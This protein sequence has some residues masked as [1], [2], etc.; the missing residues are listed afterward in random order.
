MPEFHFKTGDYIKGNY[1]PYGITNENMILGR[2][3][4]SEMRYGEPCIMV[5]FLINSLRHSRRGFYCK[6][7]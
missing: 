4:G 7:N 2:V 3:L 1:G 6:T 5:I